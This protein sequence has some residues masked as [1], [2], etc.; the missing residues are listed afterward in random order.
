[1]EGDWRED[2]VLDAADDFGIVAKSSVKLKNL[3]TE[4]AIKNRFKKGQVSWYRALKQPWA[5]KEERE[6]HDS[7]IKTLT[8]TPEELLKMG[9]K[10]I[11]ET[12]YI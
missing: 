3:F 1:M 4:N 5:L 8:I 11:G 2:K 9:V 12:T 7:F 6:Q 10:K